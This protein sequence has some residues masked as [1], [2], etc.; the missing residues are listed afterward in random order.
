MPQPCCRNVYEAIRGPE[1]WTM[2]RNDCNGNLKTPRQIRPASIQNSESRVRNSES[3][4]NQDE[5]VFCFLALNIVPAHRDCRKIKILLRLCL[6]WG[7]LFGAK[8]T[9]WLVWRPALLLGSA[10]SQL[11]MLVPPCLLAIIFGCKPERDS[12]S[13]EL[14]KLFSI[15]HSAFVCF[16]PQELNTCFYAPN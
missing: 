11:V 1:L 3:P 16:P 5:R 12:W 2:R 13:W 10:R 7:L 6:I 15:T 9:G 4:R 8:M 14:A